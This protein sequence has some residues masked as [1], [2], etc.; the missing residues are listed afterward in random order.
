MTEIDSLDIKTSV[1]KAINDVFDKMLSMNVEV[2]DTET[3][4]NID[5]NKFVGSVSFTGE[6][7]GRMSVHVSDAFA[8]LITASMLGLELDEIE[9]EGEVYDVIGEL[10]NMIGGNLKSYFCDSGLPCELS[11]PTITSGSDFNIDSTGWMRSENI[12]FR[13]QQHTAF[14][15]VHTKQSN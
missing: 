5:E 14:V 8:H 9:G 13:H 3:H 7:M 6:L 12:T 2:L 4:E 1:T 11:V 15:E 10:S